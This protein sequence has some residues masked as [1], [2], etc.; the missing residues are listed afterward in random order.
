MSSALGSTALA[1][2]LAALAP[3]AHEAYVTAVRNAA[4]ALKAQRQLLEEGVQAHVR[5]AEAS[6]VGR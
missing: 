2:C 4:N 5:S 6:Q 3:A 1:L